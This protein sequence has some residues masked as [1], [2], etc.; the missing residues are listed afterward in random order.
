METLWKFNQFTK[1]NSYSFCSHWLDLSQDKTHAADSQH[2]IE[3]DFFKNLCLKTS[4]AWGNSIYKKWKQLDDTVSYKLHMC[5]ATLDSTIFLLQEQ[6]YN[7]AAKILG[8]LQPK[9][10]NLAG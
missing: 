1:P 9:K 2:M 8:H 4:I 5:A 10:R 6:I 3:S 7:E